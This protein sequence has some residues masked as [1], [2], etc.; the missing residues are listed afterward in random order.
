MKS[1]HALPLISLAKEGDRHLGEAAPSP[2]AHENCLP[3]WQPQLGWRRDPMHPSWQNQQEQFV[4]VHKLRTSARHPGSFPPPLLTQGGL[5]IS[6]QPAVWKTPGCAMGLREILFPSLMDRFVVYT[7]NYQLFH[8]NNCSHIVSLSLSLV[9]MIH[10]VWLP[11]W[12]FQN[13]GFKSQPFPLPS[14]LL[15]CLV[16]GPERSVSN[17][18]NIFMFCWQKVNPGIS[19][20]GFRKNICLFSKGMCVGDQIYESEI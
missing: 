17:H 10:A 12:H 3:G 11:S 1:K 7:M 9:F 14:S 2:E 15:V 18:D 16:C 20:T 19:Q 8:C 13:E 5:A 6:T 4:A